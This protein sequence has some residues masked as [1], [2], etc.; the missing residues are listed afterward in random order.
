MIPLMY[1]DEEQ[2]IKLAEQYMKNEYGQ[3]LVD[4]IN[5]QSTK[6]NNQL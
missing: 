5:E 2:L 6:G 4:I 1:I 3:Y